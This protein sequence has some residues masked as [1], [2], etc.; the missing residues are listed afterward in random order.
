MWKA[1]TVP[2]MGG[3]PRATGFGTKPA[4][5][6]QS[7]VYLRRKDE[8]PDQPSPPHY[9]SPTIHPIISAI[10]DAIHLIQWTTPGWSP[11]S[12]TQAD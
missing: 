12:Q 3:T 11:R 10:L 9:P 8:T 2:V 4:L 7:K 5:L 6:G 1:S